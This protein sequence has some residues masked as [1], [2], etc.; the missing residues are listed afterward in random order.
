MKDEKLLESFKIG[1][2]SEKAYEKAF[3]RINFSFPTT[4]MPFFQDPDA[5]IKEAKLMDEAVKR[6]KP[7]TQDEINEA[8][9]ITPDAWAW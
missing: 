3:R 5:H 2:I 8:F 9:D 6:G 7:L 4:L 1:E